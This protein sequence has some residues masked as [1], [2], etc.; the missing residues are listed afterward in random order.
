MCRHQLSSWVSVKHL[1][2]TNL[3]LTRVNR[4]LILNS[5]SYIHQVRYISNKYIEEVPFIANLLQIHQLFWDSLQTASVQMNPQMGQF[6][7]TFAPQLP[8][9]TNDQLFKDLL[10][11]LSLMIGVASNFEWNVGEHTPPSANIFYPDA[12]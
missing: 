7:S 10:D 6:A 1:I 3:G 9:N 4:F 8:P 2:M 12:I 11:V 5:F